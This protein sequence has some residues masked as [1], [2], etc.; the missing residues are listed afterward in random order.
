SRTGYCALGSVKANVGHTGAAAGIAGLIKAVHVANTGSLPAHPLFE[1][2]RD[3]GLLADSPFYVP[4]TPGRTTDPDRHV[5]VHSMGLG[6]TNAAVV[7]AAPP[8]AVSPPDTA[9]PAAAP[10]VVRLQL[11]ARTRVEL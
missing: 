2:P 1:R 5:L 10:E 7:L 6:G 3:P 4:T 9:Q 11:S 8:A